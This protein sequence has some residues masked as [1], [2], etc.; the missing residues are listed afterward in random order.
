MAARRYLFPLLVL[1]AFCTAPFAASAQEE[2][3]PD[4]LI[5]SSEGFLDAHPDLKY[6]QAGLKAYEE[7]DHAEA[8]NLFR[9]AARFADKP[10]QGMI[11][12]MLWRGEGIEQDRPSAY[13][14]M[15]L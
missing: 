2:N 12:E 6:R 11:A 9:R 4:K 8:M 15:D 7:G 3:V 13:A 10:S 14:W 1:A 5:M